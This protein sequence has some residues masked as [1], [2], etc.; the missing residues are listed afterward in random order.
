MRVMEHIY[1]ALT[2]YIGMYVCYLLPIAYFSSLISTSVLSSIRQ[3]K[4]IGGRG[5]VTVI[6][7]GVIVLD[8]VRFL[9]LLL[10]GT[11]KLLPPAMLFVKYGIGA[12]A[13]LLVV[14]YA[15][16]THFAPHAAGEHFQRRLATLAV[17]VVCSLILGGIGMVM[18]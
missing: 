12:F 13:W 1:G 15:Y 8:F 16:D 5:A 6:A 14:W 4:S 18:S 2:K 7:M 3:Q 11:G 10:T 9:Y 17:F